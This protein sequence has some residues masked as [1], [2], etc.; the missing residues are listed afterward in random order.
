MKVENIVC[1][2]RI[3]GQINMQSLSNN[4]NIE[5]CPEIFPGA[6]ARYGKKVITIY[7]SGKCLLTGLKSIDEIQFLTNELQLL[8]KDITDDKEI[9]DLKIVN[10]VCSSN[11]ECP[12]NLPNLFKEIKEEGKDVS[13]DPETSHLLILRTDLCTYCINPSGK[14]IMC[15]LSSIE[16]AYKAEEYIKTLIKSHIR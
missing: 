14:Y 9:M 5:Y 8:L 1:S 13:Y 10:V 16:E 11:V 7:S 6:F 2:C 15:G 3:C 12:L 4:P